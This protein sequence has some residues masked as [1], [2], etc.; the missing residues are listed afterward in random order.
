MKKIILY[1]LIAP[2]LSILFAGVS[3]SSNNN[4]LPDLGISSDTVSNQNNASSTK[5]SN[6]KDSPLERKTSEVLV[7]EAQS[8]F[9]NLTPEGMKSE[10]LQYGKNLATATAQS[11]IESLL[12]PYGHVA[13]NLSIND[14][15]SLEGSSLDYLIPWYE[16]ESDL[17][18]S[19]FSVHN[20]DGRTVANMGT[21][22]RHN[23]N[24]DWMLG[25]NLFYDRDITRGHHRAGLGGEA[26]TNF[27]KLSSNYYMPLSSWKDSPD[28]DDYQER[29][30]RGWDIRLQA[31]LPAYPQLGSSVVY[32]QYYGDQV[33][34]FGKDSL[35]EDPS[36]VT[37][38]IDYTPVPLITVQAGYKK[39]DSAQ[40]EV[41]ANIN[42]DYRIGVSLSKQ[43]D[44]DEV[45]KMRSLAGSRMDFVDRNN[46]IVLEYR[47]KNDLDVGLYLKPTGTAAACILSDDPDSAEAYEGCHWTA[48][49]TV[50]SHLKIKSAKW[51][52]VSN[53][54]PESTLGLPALT[55]ESISNGQNNHWTLTF[56]A[57][58]DSTDPSANKYRLAVTLVDDK[59]HTKQSNTVNIIV[60][61][62]P[63][64]YQLVIDDSGEQK[65]AIK[66]LA[67][68]N[69]FANLHASG[70]KVTGLAGETTPLDAKNLNLTFHAYKMEDKSHSQEIAIH[71]S[72]SDCKSGGECLFFKEPPSGSQA[73]LGST[74]NGVF[75]VIASKHDDGTQKTNAVLVDFSSASTMIYSAIVD[76]ENPTV[77]L[78]ATKGN[79]L[80]LG[81][82]YQFKI[83]YDSNNNGQWDATDRETVSDSDPT[84][85]ISL[86]DYKWMF[87]GISPN[88]TKGGYAVSATE[89]NTILIPKT[90]AEASQVLA[91]AG[92]DGVQG[93]ELKVDY[94]LTPSGQQI[95]N[96]LR[97]K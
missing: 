94:Q 41:T 72:K 18:F 25:S 39:G 97:A 4:T 76:S 13:T 65:K 38:G 95:M 20:K 21:G 57:W 46:D 83:A 35:Q 85:L 79:L 43:L 91:N 32:E 51:V 40:R 64:D 24:E 3:Y 30:A 56:P 80:Q 33:A 15:G 37:V 48:N 59:G 6:E 96:K 63:I 10:A 77:N 50:T 93:Y 26:W 42:L 92:A 14:R 53:F 11:K 34:L 89:N 67:N 1:L 49:A 90:N 47:E 36:A 87:D 2:S 75:S 52:P 70:A 7:N 29:P 81:H 69:N 9:Q 73:I 60:A 66:L 74:M 8:H 16:G 17:W 27:L 84:P 12:S 19:Q 31:Y 71:A 61:E 28:F 88:G 54:N 62:A 44:G 23:L 22:I 86:V 45:A 68:G 5:V 82:K 55:A 78:T 58:V